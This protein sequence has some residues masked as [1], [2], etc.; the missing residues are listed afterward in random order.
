MPLARSITLRASSRDVASFTWP[1]ERHRL[2]V[3]REG[4]L[5]GRHQLGA[6]EGLHEVGLSPGVTRLLDEVALAERR[7][8]QHSGRAPLVDAARG[9]DA[10]ESRAS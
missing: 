5:D 8:D 2:A 3:A 10:V 6:L 1:L 4:E 9:L 7:E